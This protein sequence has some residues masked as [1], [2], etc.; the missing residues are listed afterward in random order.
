[1]YADV[2]DRRS[3]DRDLG[4][5]EKGNFWVENLVICL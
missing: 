3:R 1:M 5:L 4:T 2:G